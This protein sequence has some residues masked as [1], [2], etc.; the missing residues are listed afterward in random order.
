MLT[1]DER[2]SRG[3][4]Y[5]N[6]YRYVC[7]AYFDN[8]NG[9]KGLYASRQPSVFQHFLMCMFYCKIVSPFCHNTLTWSSFLVKKCISVDKFNN[10]KQ[11][12]CLL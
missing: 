4:A 6:D 2:L 10:W 9:D 8:T 5:V 3:N 7:I 12:F 1:G 11:V